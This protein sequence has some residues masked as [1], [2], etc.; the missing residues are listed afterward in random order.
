MNLVDGVDFLFGFGVASGWLGVGVAWVWMGL[1]E[2][3]F[4]GFGWFGFG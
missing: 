1:S 3:A 2:L 4:G